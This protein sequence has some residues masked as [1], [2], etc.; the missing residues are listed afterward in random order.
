MSQWLPQPSKH[1]SLGVIVNTLTPWVS[2][3][4]AISVIAF[5]AR[6]VSC[7]SQRCLYYETHSGMS[8]GDRFHCLLCWIFASARS[9]SS[10][11]KTPC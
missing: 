9:T 2:F 4:V 7:D 1:F 3:S 11:V 10:L 8:H 6:F 5:G